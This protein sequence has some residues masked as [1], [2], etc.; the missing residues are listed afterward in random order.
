MIIPSFAEATLKG[1]TVTSD[2]ISIT[3]YAAGSQS[4]FFLYIVDAEGNEFNLP[5]HMLKILSGKQLENLREKIGK[6]IIQVM[7]EANNPLH[8]PECIPAGKGSSV[9]ILAKDEYRIGQD[10]I[11]TLTWSDKN[12]GWVLNLGSSDIWLG[13]ANWDD[14]VEVRQL[15]SSMEDNEALSVQLALINPKAASVL[16]SRMLLD[17]LHYGQQ[18]PVLDV[19]S[20]KWELISQN[21]GSK[22]EKLSMNSQIVQKGLGEISTAALMITGGE[23]VPVALQITPPETPIFETDML[24]FQHPIHIK[25]HEIWQRRFKDFIETSA[26]WRFVSL[27][28]NPDALC[29]TAIPEDM[30][31]KIL[32]AIESPRFLRL[33]T[34]FF[35]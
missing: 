15:V 34:P 23:Y 21:L 6:Q 7:R 30:W 13:F 3:L 29:I 1:E 35:F 24:P 5:H 31:A 16:A 26:T 22:R 27:P 14:A 20:I 33:D 19:V 8:F 2:G 10:G 28:T 11:P 32:P 12:L 25:N 18:L 17:E 9:I 4:S